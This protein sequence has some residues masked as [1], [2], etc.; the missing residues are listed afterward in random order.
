MRCES[1]STEELDEVRSERPDWLRWFAAGGVWVGVVVEEEGLEEGSMSMWGMED[2]GMGR[3]SII[4]R[5]N[6]RSFVLFSSRVEG[7]EDKDLY[8]RVSNS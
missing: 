7:S 1:S 8:K 5:A 2:S 4:S 3:C 6:S